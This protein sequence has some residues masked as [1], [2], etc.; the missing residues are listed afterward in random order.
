MDVSGWLVSTITTAPLS[1]FD[2]TGAPSYGAQV[3]LPCRI[4]LGQKLVRSK[5]GAEVVSS[6][7][8]YVVAQIGIEDAIW[9]PGDSTSDPTVAKYPLNIT[10]AYDKAGNV[11]YWRV[12]L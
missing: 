11:L 12:D 10:A 2:S 5:D 1:S 8:V 7:R 4:E 3:T 6:H 9:L